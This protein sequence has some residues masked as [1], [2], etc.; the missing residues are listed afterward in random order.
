LVGIRPEETIKYEVANRALCLD[1]RNLPLFEGIHVH[2]GVG[3]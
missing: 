3:R 1:R 2:V